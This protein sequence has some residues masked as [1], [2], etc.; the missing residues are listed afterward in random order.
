M[1]IHFTDPLSSAWAR[2]K[3]ALFQPFNLEKWFTIG[4]T[5]FLAALVDGRGGGGGGNHEYGYKNANWDEL[6]NFPGVAME[7]MS[8]NPV[9]ATLIVV[10]IG[11]LFVLG[12]VL[13]WLSSRGKFMFLDN[14][15]HDKAEVTKPWHEFSKQG[16]SLFLW[17]LVYGLICLVIIILS[18]YA[19]YLHLAYNMYYGFHRVSLPRFF[20]ILAMIFILLCTCLLLWDIF[21]FSSIVLLFLSCIKEGSLQRKPGVFL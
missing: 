20:I 4:F 3:K 7:W 9:W 1:N 17:R 16:N 21:R 10:G 11:F 12:I 6:F 8:N 5:A 2:M 14:V 19:A 18:F 15:V 13:T